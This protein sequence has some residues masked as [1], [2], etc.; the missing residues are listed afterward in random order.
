MGTGARMRSR[1]S[2]WSHLWWRAAQVRPSH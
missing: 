2:L 1:V